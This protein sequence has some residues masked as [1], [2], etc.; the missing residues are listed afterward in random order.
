MQDVSSYESF[1][2]TKTLSG[3]EVHVVGELVKETIKRPIEI[4]LKNTSKCPLVLE[5]ERTQDGKA[6]TV[7]DWA[8]TNLSE[9]P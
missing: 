5:N 9:N 1:S 6:K 8:E 3:S 2:S 7:Y 4:S